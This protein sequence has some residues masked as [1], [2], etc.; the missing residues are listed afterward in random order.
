[1]ID[2][3]PNRLL[4]SSQK[5]IIDYAYSIVLQDVLNSC[6]GSSINHSTYSSEHILKQT[7]F[8]ACGSTWDPEPSEIY[9]FFFVVVV[10]SGIGSLK[11]I[12]GAGCLGGPSE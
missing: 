9:V 4:Y 2:G 6:V 7:I 12:L 5:D 10:R 1:M 11:V 8:M 3:I